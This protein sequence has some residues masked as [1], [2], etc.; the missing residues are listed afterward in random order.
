MKDT[1]ATFLAVAA[2]HAEEGDLGMIELMIEKMGSEFE[3][4]VATA[5]SEEAE[6]VKKVLK[7]LMSLSEG[8]W[9]HV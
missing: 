8:A 1:I 6:D 5:G 3:S 4:P 7:T 2:D 9:R